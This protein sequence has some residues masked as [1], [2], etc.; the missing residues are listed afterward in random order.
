MSE[1]GSE[2]ATFYSY[3]GGSGRSMHLANVAWVLASNGKRVL[4]IDW[5]L[6]A[7]GLHRYFRPFL[8][9]KDLVATEGI[10][11]LMWAFTDAAMTPVPPAEQRQGWHEAYA[12]LSPYI[13]AV[14]GAFRSPGRL[15][16]LPAG[17]QGASYSHRV[18]SFN[19]Q[20][21]YDRLGGG[22][23]L[24]SLRVWMRRE[25]DYVLV[26]SRTGVSDTAGICTVQMPDT[27]VICFTANNQSIEGCASV[28]E[29]IRA[30][31]AADDHRKQQHRI[32]PVLMRVDVSEKAKLD[33][34]RA[35]T[36]S[37]FDQYVSSVALDPIED[38]WR[39]I[40]VPSC[41]GTP[42]RKYSRYSLTST[43]SESLCW[44]R[45]RRWH[46]Y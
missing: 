10:I 5:D 4:M 1:H 23:F 14:Q 46:E 8:V 6:E 15:D 27:L 41:R 36:R 24:E 25:Y 11:D 38:Y 32:L 40:E 43:G 37:K 28:V 22:V 34:R 12:D 30:Q 16:L 3:K 19:W 29:S 20:G 9:D 26:D 42:T 33:A 7:P 45:R 35:I 21:F 18:N 2:I 13:V 17:K 44:S 39:D 31:W